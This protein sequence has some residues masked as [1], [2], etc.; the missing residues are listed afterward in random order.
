MAVAPP[1][2]TPLAEGCPASRAPSIPP[3]NASAM[4][5]SNATKGMRPSAPIWAMVTC[6]PNMTMPMRRKV[7]LA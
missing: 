3:P 7:R 5:T 1:D 4:T 2:S 6:V